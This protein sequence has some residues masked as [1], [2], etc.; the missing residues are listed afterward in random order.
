MTVDPSDLSVEDKRK[1]RDAI[2]QHSPD[3]LAFMEELR[4]EFG[5]VRLEYVQINNVVE[6]GRQPEQMFDAVAAKPVTETLKEWQKE[7]DAEI[8]RLEMLGRKRRPT[9]RK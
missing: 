1:L 2:A 9:R 8:A 7:V 4:K 5:P 6:I 3:M